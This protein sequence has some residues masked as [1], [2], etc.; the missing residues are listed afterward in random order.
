MICISDAT[1]ALNPIESLMGRVADSDGWWKRF[2]P[3]FSALMISH[4]CKPYVMRRAVVP[5]GPPPAKTRGALRVGATGASGATE[6]TAE[7]SEAAE[8]F[9]SAEARPRKEPASCPLTEPSP[10]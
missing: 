1:T 3:S 4:W 10:N 2:K 5:T 6:Q 9:Y 8:E 7:A